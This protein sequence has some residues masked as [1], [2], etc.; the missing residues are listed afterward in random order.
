LSRP[1][2]W[3]LAKWERAG[4]PATIR[5]ASAYREMENVP[6]YAHRVIVAVELRNPT[7][8]GQPSA[9]EWD[10]LK[11]FELNVCRVLEADNECLCVLVITGNGLRDIFFY[12]KNPGTVRERISGAK[13]QLKSHRFQ[14]AIE[15]EVDWRVYRSF[16]KMLARPTSPETKTSA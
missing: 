2:A 9:D 15:Q 8:A 1:D 3:I 4:Y 7:E 5:L 13:K 16:A 14:L 11:A 6:G 12:A 10:D